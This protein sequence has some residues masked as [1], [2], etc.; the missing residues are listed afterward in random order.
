MQEMW[1]WLQ[2]AFL[3]L[4]VMQAC[5]VL[6]H[7]QHGRNI[8]QRLI[9]KKESSQRRQWQDQE[10]GRQAQSVSCCPMQNQA[11]VSFP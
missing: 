9:V 1:A 11:N 6:G 4:L 8:L 10:T 5:W 2:C 3:F 7:M